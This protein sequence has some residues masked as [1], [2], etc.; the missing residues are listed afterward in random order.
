MRPLL[1][2]GFG[3]LATLAL[4]AAAAN[5]APTLGR[6][7]PVPPVGVGDRLV[8]GV[9]GTTLDR[10]TREALAKGR[11]A[12]II[13]LSSN[14]RS[15]NQVRRL[16]RAA[17]DAA[18][19]AGLPE[20]IICTDQEGGRVNRLGK[21]P[22]FPSDP[23]SARLARRGPAYIKMQARKVGAA[24]ADLGFNVDL[25]PDTDLD[26]GT[27]VIGDRS[28]GK[29]PALVVSC[30]SAAVRGVR[31][32]GVYTVIKHYP[33]HG[34]VKGDSHKGLPIAR[35]SSATLRRHEGVFDAVL[36]SG[37]NGVMLGHILVPS[38]DPR[39]PASLSRA[40]AGDLRKRLGKDK[41]IFTDSG[42]MGALAGFGRQSDRAA[43]ALNAGVDV[44]LTTTPYASLGSRFAAQVANEVTPGRGLFESSSRVRR[45]R[46]G[47][48][49]AP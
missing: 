1:A 19:S 48:R 10:I 49:P 5:H 2:I 28:F 39:Y 24:L 20:P 6:S 36:Q 26:K 16:T 11:I 17:S 29:D 27:G 14:I 22:G 37:A 15:W 35:V 25:A 9:T 13:L 38:V 45:W 21:L 8:V 33:G 3:M 32:A 4:P 23:S 7:R 30:A 31:E 40:F 44:Y 41:L 12:G 42:S 43:R 18:K 34:L 46:R 47:L